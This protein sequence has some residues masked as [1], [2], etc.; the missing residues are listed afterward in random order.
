MKENIFS[1]VCPKCG[2]NNWTYRTYKASTNLITCRDCLYTGLPFETDEKGKQ[3]LQKR[4]KEGKTVDSEF[5]TIETFGFWKFPKKFL[6]PKGIYRIIVY[7][8]LFAFLC[9]MLLLAL[10]VLGIL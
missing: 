4:F 1:K 3:E 5:E 10:L 8:S 7:L 9:G 6:Y 2:S